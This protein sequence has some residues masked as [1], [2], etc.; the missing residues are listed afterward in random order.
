MPF[1]EY[2]LIIRLALW[3]GTKYGD[4][5]A[6]SVTGVVQGVVD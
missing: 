5:E 1:I 4:E 2:P 6:S 3:Y